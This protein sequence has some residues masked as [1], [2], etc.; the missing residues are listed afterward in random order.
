M[1]TVS[2][3]VT[4]CTYI[5]CGILQNL[6]GSTCYSG[7]KVRPWP[8]CSKLTTLL[9]NVLLKFQMLIFEMAKNFVKKCEK[10]LQCNELVKL[11][12]LRTTG[13][14]APDEKG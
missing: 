2:P 7:A 4:K 8:C 12:I 6:C 11:T 1:T 10:L 3:E 13:P 14:I 9:G 5:Q